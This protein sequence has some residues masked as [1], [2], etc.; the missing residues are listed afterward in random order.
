MN[1]S[2]CVSIS[3]SLIAGAFLIITGFCGLFSDKFL[4]LF[5]TNYLLGIFTIVLGAGSIIMS[6]SKMSVAGCTLI[7][8]ILI[9]MGVMRFIP[10]ADNIIIQLWNI[11]YPTAYLFIGL[12]AGSLFAAFM[13]ND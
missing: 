1:E 5:S 9:A 13:G 8:W 7:G 11:N 10:A 2:G 3:F 6:L 4:W 12:G